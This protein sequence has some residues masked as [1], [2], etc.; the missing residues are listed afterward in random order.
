MQALVL[1]GGKGTRINEGNARLPKWLLPTHDGTPIIRRLLVQLKTLGI[2]RIIVASGPSITY[3][4]VIKALVYDIYPNLEI[5]AD[6]GKNTLEAVYE[7]SSLFYTNEDV[8]ISVADT[9]V[10]LDALRSVVFNKGSATMLTS[11]PSDIDNDYMKVSLRDGYVIEMAKDLD[12]SKCDAIA[13]GTIHK[14]SAKDI[15]MYQIALINARSQARERHITNAH[16]DWAL[17]IAARLG[18]KI[19]GVFVNDGEWAEVDTKAD[20]TYMRQLDI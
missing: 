18:V 2:P 10:T 6:S 7:A 13:V 3:A 17:P 19:R 14:I 1:A 9:V 16:G 11:T 15:P 8:V 4:D 5:H 12:V 20:L